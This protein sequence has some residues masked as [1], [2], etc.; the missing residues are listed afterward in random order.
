MTP[1]NF[2]FVQPPFQIPIN[3]T[4]GFEQFQNFAGGLD[5]TSLAAGGIRTICLVF[6]KA[7]ATPA[8]AASIM[9]VNY[10]D[11]T[12]SNRAP[13]PLFKVPIDGSLYDFG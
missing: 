11:F 2:G 13:V 8:T 3:P 4:G 5:P 6:R 9:D 7:T 12:V 10:F 1:T